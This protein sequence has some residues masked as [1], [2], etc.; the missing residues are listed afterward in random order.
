MRDVAG[1]WR[2]SL[3]RGASCHAMW[4]DTRARRV[5]PAAMI[6]QALVLAVSRPIV[7]EQSSS[8]KSGQ[9]VG[10]VFVIVMIALVLWKL[11]KWIKK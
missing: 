4:R 5:H 8:Y 3:D 10:R 9:A 11:V 2:P 7:D 6:H 1:A